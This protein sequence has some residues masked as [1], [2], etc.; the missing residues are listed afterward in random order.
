[1]SFKANKIVD[2]SV[3]Y[4]FQL[5]FIGLKSK[6]VSTYTHIHWYNDP[7]NHLDNNVHS[8]NM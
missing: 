6:K 2:L 1:M 3:R 5:H 8:M 7:F 4:F